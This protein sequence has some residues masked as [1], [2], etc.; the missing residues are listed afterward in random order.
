MKH[1]ALAS[2]AAVA[3]LVLSGC[4]TTSGVAP[5]VT[6]L[7]TASPLPTATATPSLKPSPAATGRTTQ[8]T[9][10]PRQAAPEPTTQTAPAASSDIPGDLGTVPEGFK[11]PEEDRP[12]DGETTAFTTSVWRASCPDKV[13]TLASASGLTGTRVKESIGPEHA[14]TN[15]LLVF[16]DEAAA[17]AFMTELSTALD[18]C[19]P[20]GPAEDGWR[21]VQETRALTGIGEE[22]LSTSSWSQWDDNGKW[23]EGPGAGLSYVARSG[24]YVVI[25]QEGGEYVGDP[26]DL[27]DVVLDLE[28]RTT[29]MLEQL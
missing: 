17:Q 21:T 28:T 22:A 16:A 6:P 29:A 1:S 27:P 8:A 9:P 10:P 14:V 13:L 15:G 11:L 7:P 3:L 2:A 26:A 25:A 20:E 19:T 12:G 24:Q 18:A 5:T 23:A 4:S